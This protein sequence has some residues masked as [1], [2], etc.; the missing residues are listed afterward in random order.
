MFPKKTR[1]RPRKDKIESKN[2]EAIDTKDVIE[3]SEVIPD[4]LYPPLPPEHLEEDDD[5]VRAPDQSFN[6][7][8]IPPDDEDDN[9]LNELRNSINGS[10]LYPPDTEL[11]L[12]LEM[13]MKENPNYNDNLQ[14]L[15]EMLI[16]SKLEFEEHLKNKKGER[17][18]VLSNFYRKLQFLQFSHV[19]EQ[20]NEYFQCNIDIIY[21]DNVTYKSIFEII[22]S[23]YK[24]PNEKGRKCAISEEE[25]GVLRTIFFIKD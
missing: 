8:L 19:I 15:N 10:S 4:I 7:C 20:L 14:E 11:Q 22:D 5:K 23:Y 1:G 13:S 2:N 17:K 21:L 6:E 12:A 25:D 3:H 16:V 24:I 9:I 18:R